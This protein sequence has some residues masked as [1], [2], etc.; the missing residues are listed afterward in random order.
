MIG[1]FVG[2][3]KYIRDREVWD[4]DWSRRSGRQYI[5]E[6]DGCIRELGVAVAD[7]YIVMSHIVMEPT[8]GRQLP[9]AV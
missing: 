6:A 5:C 4:G 9:R 1:G 3:E 8:F 7:G 2:W